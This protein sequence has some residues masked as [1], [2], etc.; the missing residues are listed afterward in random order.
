MYRMPSI[1]THPPE[2]NTYSI[3]AHTTWWPHEGVQ[4]LMIMQSTAA[5][6]NLYL[7]VVFL[8]NLETIHFEYIVNIMQANKCGPT[9]PNWFHML[10]II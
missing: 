3:Y 5:Y 9:L 4:V 1:C 8:S 2:E 7:I 6:H 10:P